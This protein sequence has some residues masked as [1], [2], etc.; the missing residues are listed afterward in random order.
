MR[1]KLRVISDHYRELGKS[2]S[3]V[4]DAHG[5]RIGRAP[6][7]DWILPDPDRYVSSHHCRV[8]HKGGRWILEDTSTNGVFVNGSTT[9]VAIEGGHVLADGDRMRLGDYEILVSLD[10]REEPAEQPEPDANPD[11][12]RTPRT[13]R[14]HT[15][16]LGEDLDLSALLGPA[17][18]P[19]EPEPRRN[20]PRTPPARP[21]APPP[22]VDGRAGL[23]S[24]LDG[25]VDTGPE[26]TVVHD[27]QTPDWALKT[28]PLRPA[29]PATPKEPP[30]RSMAPAPR[31]SAGTTADLDAAIDAFCRGAGVDPSGLSIEAQSTLLTLAGQMLRETVVGL[32][33]GLRARQDF[34]SQMNLEQTT[35]QPAENNPLKFANSVDDAIRNLLDAHGNRYL[36]PVESLREGFLDLRTHHHAVVAALAVALESYLSRFSP[37]ELEQGFDRGLKRGG[38][39]GA[40]NKSKYWDLYRDFYQLVTQ[41]GADGLPPAFADDLGRAYDERAGA[42]R[43]KSRRR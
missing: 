17:D 40:A 11:R 41:K 4:F 2:S 30:T 26:R 43:K 7:N 22:R 3:R 31:R 15:E 25:P 5:G 8:H 37:E 24:L 32:M 16:D 42:L 20:P 10:D 21:A 18:H 33:E 29:P 39:L 28:R 23:T 19:R 13:T 14:Y 35:I 34:K 6:D 36:S 27:K 38:L 12:R 1:L 9:P